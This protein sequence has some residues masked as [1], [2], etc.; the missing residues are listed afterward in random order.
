MEQV[1]VHVP[2]SGILTCFRRQ[3]AA[4]IVL[5]LDLCLLIP[6]QSYG[7]S[8]SWMDSTEEEVAVWASM[9][10]NPNCWIETTLPVRS[11]L[12]RR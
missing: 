11:N 9:I 1:S 4:V 3:K 7:E 8:V 10:N 12:T 2:K 5:S 6:G